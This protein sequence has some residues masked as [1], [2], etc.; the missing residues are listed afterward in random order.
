VRLGGDARRFLVS[1]GRVER[2]AGGGAE[3]AR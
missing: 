1:E 2:A 3:K